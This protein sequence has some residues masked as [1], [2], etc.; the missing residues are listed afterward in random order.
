VLDSSQDLVHLHFVK[1]AEG[2]N[3]TATCTRIVGGFFK[4][5]DACIKGNLIYVLE[6][7]SGNNPVKIL[8]VTLPLD[9]LSITTGAIPTSLCPDQQVSVPYTVSGPF[10]PGNIFTAQLSKPSGSFTAPLTIG[11]FSSTVSGTIDAHIPS[12][13]SGTAYRIRVREQQSML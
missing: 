12:N 10:N 13:G 8:E 4:P 3:Y 1:N 5:V 11:T 9:T 2:D 7:S 6:Y